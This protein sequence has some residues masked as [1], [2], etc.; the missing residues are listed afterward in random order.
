MGRKDDYIKERGRRAEAY[1]KSIPEDVLGPA[2]R[3]LVSNPRQLRK[4]PL[5]GVKGEYSDP[6][7]MVQ[8]PLIGVVSDVSAE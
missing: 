8:P 6:P 5:H 4:E 2:G 7:Q 3:I 1:L